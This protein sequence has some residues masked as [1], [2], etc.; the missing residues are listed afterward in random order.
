MRQGCLALMLVLPLAAPPA[1]AGEGLV[2]T[3]VVGDAIPESLTG[4]AGDAAR[5]RA[6]V[7]DRTRGLCLLCHAG[8]F[9]EERF[10]GNL[11]PD[12]AG[13]GGRLSSGQL[14]LRLVDGRALNPDTIMPSYYSL[15]GLTRVGRLWRGRPILSAAEIED[16]VAFL[17][18]LRGAGPEESR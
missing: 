16:I 1:Q 3:T 17:A 13:V 9:P 11:A 5:G 2:P 4:A 12:L 18:T 10:Q 7:V 14:R 6:I 15:T 8:P